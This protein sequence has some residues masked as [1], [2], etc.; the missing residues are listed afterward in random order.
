MGDVP[1]IVKIL[2]DEEKLGRPHSKSHDSYKQLHTLEDYQKEIEEQNIQL[3]KLDKIKSNFLNVTSHEL[4]TPMSSIKGYIQLILKRKLGEITEEQRKSLEIVLKNAN[5]LDH[6]IQDILDIS[7]LES[8][9]M[10]FI[11]GKTNV[12]TMVEE[13][14]ETMQSSADVK[15]IKINTDIE[16]NISDL[17]VDQER[18]EQVLINLVNNAIKFSLD[19][20]NIDI[21]VRR[22]K[23][24]I[25]FEIQDFGRGIPENKKDTIFDAFYQVNLGEDKKLGG[26]G[27]GLAISRGIVLA[28]GGRIWVE[29]ILDR[30]STFA[31]ILPV[32]PVQDVE[33]RFKEVDVFGVEDS[34]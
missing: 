16:N 22:E 25:L 1:E 17:T 13:T 23:D 2:R 26:V 30:G 32:K 10:K 8:G 18:I 6:L 21:K 33:G 7:R 29:S 5:R 27:L 12:R 24:D 15:H 19:N 4:R 3:K 9:R 34:R 28:H 31:F 11:P 20:S 14:A